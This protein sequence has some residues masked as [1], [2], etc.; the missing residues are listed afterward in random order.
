MTRAWPRL[1]AEAGWEPSSSP[2]TRQESGAWLAARGS[3]G[4]ASSC[5]SAVL[6]RVSPDKPGR[7]S[8]CHRERCWAARES[9]PLTVLVYSEYAL[10]VVLGDGRA[11]SELPLVQFARSEARHYRQFGGIEGRHVAAHKGNAGN[12]AAGRLAGWLADAGRRRLT[13]PEWVAVLLRTADSSRARVMFHRFGRQESAETVE[14][15]T[16]R[17]QCCFS[18][19]PSCHVQAARRPR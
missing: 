12:E 14:L 3:S 11:L 6:G 5:C 18:C 16:C 1:A 10:G 19:W 17:A 8:Y 13:V 7:R 2:W 4:D 15:T 9:I